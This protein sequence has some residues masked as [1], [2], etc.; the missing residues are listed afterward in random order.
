[1]AITGQYQP[2]GTKELILSAWRNHGDSVRLGWPIIKQKSDMNKFS[3]SWRY[4]GIPE[5]EM[6]GINY[7]PCNATDRNPPKLYKGNS[8]KYK[9]KIRKQNISIFGPKNIFV[10]YFR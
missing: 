7:F 8:E 9:G 5:E 2:Q 10:G 6:T 3:I 4:W 1:M